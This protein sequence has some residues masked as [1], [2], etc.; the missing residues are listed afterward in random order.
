[1]LINSSLTLELKVLCRVWVM[2]AYPR[3]C[4]VSVCHLS[5]ACYLVRALLGKVALPSR[6][7]MHHDT[8]SFRQKRLD[9]GVPERHVHRM[10]DLQ[11]A[12]GDQLA[13]EADFNKL[14]PVVQKLFHHIRLYRKE[15]LMTYKSN[16]YSL[17]DEHSF[18]ETQQ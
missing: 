1:M 11:W 9:A 18:K 14:D 8:A 3:Y 16:T 7:E 12:F 2:C 4:V 15:N 13:D 6:E 10:A 17:L 5:Q